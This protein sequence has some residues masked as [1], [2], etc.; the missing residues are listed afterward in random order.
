MHADVT[1]LTRLLSDDLICTHT[2]GERQTKRE[3]I[4]SITKGDI[5]YDAIEFEDSTARVYRNT[6]VTVS[7]MRI[8]LTVANTDVKLHPCLCTCG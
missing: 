6:G 3:F 7:R 1:A 5:R 4:A 8:K 2:D